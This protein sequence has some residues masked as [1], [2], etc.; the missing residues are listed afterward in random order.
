MADF[1]SLSIIFLTIFFQ[2][3]YKEKHITSSLSYTKQ[4]QS[5]SNTTLMVATIAFEFVP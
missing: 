5:Q 3:N 2:D 1:V 4:Q